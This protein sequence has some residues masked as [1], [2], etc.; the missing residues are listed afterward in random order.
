MANSAFDTM[1]EALKN[2]LDE[3]TVHKVLS[4]LVRTCGGERIYIPVKVAEP[5]PVLPTDTPK[6]IQQ[7]LGVSRRSSYRMLNRHRI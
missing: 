5:E 1:I 7:R 2:E 6:T 4:C 3:G